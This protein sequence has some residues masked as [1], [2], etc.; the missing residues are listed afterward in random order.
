M[1]VAELSDLG[2]SGVVGCGEVFAAGGDEPVGDGFEGGLVVVESGEVV[3]GVGV[4]D[5]VAATDRVEAT[6]GLTAGESDVDAGS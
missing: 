4:G 2:G 6:V 1:R 3:F 5:K